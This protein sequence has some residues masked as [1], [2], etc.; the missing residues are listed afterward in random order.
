VKVC[1]LQD[2][3]HV[4]AA[5]RADVDY[6]GIVFAAS[7]RQV[8]PSQARRLVRSLDG[9]SKRPAVVGVFV[10]EAQ[11]RVNA[12]AEQCGLDLVQLNGEEGCVYC[13]GITRPVIRTFRIF[14]ETKTA[15]L[16]R[17]IESYVRINEHRPVSF[18]LDTGVDGAHGGTGRTF[19]WRV[20]REA[21]A[22]YSVI[23][24]GGL[25]AAN[26]GQLVVQARPYGV[27]VSSGVERDGRKDP[28]LIEAFVRAVR[29]AEK[30]IVCGI[31]NNVA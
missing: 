7:R 1:G 14:A 12:I 22:S 10:N 6:V 5:A 9:L 24:A 21:S 8:T 11:Q 2:E 27:D 29:K 13:A 31:S 19:D 18:L 17:Q 3:A 30:E 23:V 16:V 4:L 20:A 15:D 28:I 26:V 25:D